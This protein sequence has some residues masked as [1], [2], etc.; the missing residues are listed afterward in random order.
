MRYNM[1]NNVLLS[2]YFFFAHVIHYYFI[3]DGV[4]I[5]PPS[6]FPKPP[7]LPPAPQLLSNFNCWVRKNTSLLRCKVSITTIH[8]EINLDILPGILPSK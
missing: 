3:E 6:G 5:D 7:P 2:F 8:V 4:D 1:T